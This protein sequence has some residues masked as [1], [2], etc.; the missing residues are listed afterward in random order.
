[1]TIEAGPLVKGRCAECG[2]IGF[3]YDFFGDFTC[4]SCHADDHR[5][6]SVKPRDTAEVA[7][8]DANR[9]DE[10]DKQ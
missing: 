9:E 6:A 2:V 8:N 1:M 3:V 7:K 4:A 5:V 10:R